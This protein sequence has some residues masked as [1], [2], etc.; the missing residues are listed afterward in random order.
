M[1]LDILNDVIY[2]HVKFYYVF[3]IAGYTKITKSDKFVD[4]KIYILSCL[5]IY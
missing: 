5:Q 2:K 4:M 1:N 3:C